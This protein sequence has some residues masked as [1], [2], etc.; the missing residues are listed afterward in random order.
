MGKPSLPGHPYSISI[1]HTKNFVG[2]LLSASASCGIDLEILHPRILKIADRF[3]SDEEKRF[4][5]PNQPL[6][7]LYVMWG[8]KEVLYKIYGK[9]NILFKKHLK[10]E[11]FAYQ[12]EGKVTAWIVKEDY[13][14]SHAIHYR[15]MGELMLTYAID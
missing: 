12:Q 14:K 3:L 6:P 7:Y 11:K 2:V 8:A 1:S 15:Q 4:M 10:V 5:P 9:G 13:S